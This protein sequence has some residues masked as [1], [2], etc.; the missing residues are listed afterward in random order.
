GLSRGADQN[1][2]R[3]SGAPTEETRGFVA[4]WMRFW[5]TPVDPVGLH[6]IRI[7]FGLLLVFWLLILFG[8]QQDFFGFA[9]WLDW[10]AVLETAKLANMPGG[11]PPPPAW[12]ILYWCG[13]D[14]NLV[15]LVYWGS[16][17]VALLFTA[18][19]APRL[20][21]VLTWVIVVSFVANPILFFDADQLLV[22]V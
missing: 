2:S 3:A 16:V 4:A 8:Y 1:S 19:I 20:T 15:N 12:S 14:A 10:Q 18:G 7:L 11:P 13:N 5:F 9:G 22:V 17:V 6:G 21:A